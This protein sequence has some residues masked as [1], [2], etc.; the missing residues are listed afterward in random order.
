LQE[1]PV[2]LAQRFERQTD[3]RAV[4][5]FENDFVAA[6]SHQFRVGKNLARRILPLAAQCPGDR[7][8][9]A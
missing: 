4:L 6:D 5:L 7:H 8:R 2:C 3:D 9:E 1:L